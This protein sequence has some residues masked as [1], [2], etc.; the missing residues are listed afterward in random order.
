[1]WNPF[2][3]L[4]RCCVIFVEDAESGSKYG[5]IDKTSRLRKE[6]GVEKRAKL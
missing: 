6:G 2:K 5:T 4:A 3:M 1:M